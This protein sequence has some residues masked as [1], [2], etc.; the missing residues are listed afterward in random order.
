ME[1]QT[2]NSYAVPIAIV[3]AGALIAG[4]VF[5]TRS[6]GNTPIT[7]GGGTASMRP[8]D[9]KDHIIGNPEAP[10]IVVEYSDTECPYCKNF[11]TTM[12]EIMATY[13]KDGKVAWVYRHFPIPS[14]HAKATKEAEA[15]ECAAELGGETK[16]WEYTNRLYEVTPSNDGLEAAQ[17]PTL[18]V[19]VGLNKNAFENCLSSGRHQARV[20]RDVQDGLAI[21]IRGT[22][23]SV[24]VAGGEQVPLEGAQPLS[25]MQ[26]FIEAVL[27]QT[28]SN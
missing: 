6:E 10:I 9:S 18:A 14:L 16:F 1:T 22:P 21:G 27:K 24:V 13:G 15:L 19:E 8:I 25:V 20:E 11:H 3:V 2:R 26:N 12:R 7:S 4:A 28:A 23:H 5:F 17:L